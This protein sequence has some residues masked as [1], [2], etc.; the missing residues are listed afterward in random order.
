MQPPTT[1]IPEPD[2]AVDARREHFAIRRSR[3]SLT[4]AWLLGIGRQRL[5]QLRRFGVK[6]ARLAI[7]AS[8]YDA[9]GVWQKNDIQRLLGMRQDPQK[10]AVFGAPD[11]GRLVATAADEQLVIRRKL[12]PIDY[13]RMA[14]QGFDDFPRG[15]FPNTDDASI[16]VASRRQPLAVG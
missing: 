10:P 5:Q 7:G 8:G 1:Q 12:D 13:G 16:A 14:F 9:F 6:D 11:S 15:N 4:K 2:L 3:H